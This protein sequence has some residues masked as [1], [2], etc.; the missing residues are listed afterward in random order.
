MVS[1]I[2]NV[3]DRYHGGYVK[4]PNAFKVGHLDGYQMSFQNLQPSEIPGLIFP[5][6]MPADVGSE[7]PP[8]L[9]E[10]QVA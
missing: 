7:L 10:E 2:F 3:N 1:A 8:S 9:R 4:L 5:G 6:A